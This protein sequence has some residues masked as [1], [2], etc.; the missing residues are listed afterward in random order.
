M[1]LPQSHRR[2]LVSAR[3]SESRR[4]APVKENKA[5]FDPTVLIAGARELG[6]ELT[7]DQLDRFEILQSTLLD[8]NQRVNLTSITDPWQI[9]VKHVL[10]SLTVLA[11]CSE[12][13]RRG[14]VRSSLVDVGSGG[15]F[16]GLPLAI[17]LPT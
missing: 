3:E 17:I 6:V 15:G 10:D 2:L 4:S 7:S 11:A 13:V 12:G 14:H 1:G 9:Q 5:A 8:W 16:P